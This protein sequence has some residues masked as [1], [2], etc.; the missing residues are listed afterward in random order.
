MYSNV[1]QARVSIRDTIWCVALTS[2]Y[3]GPLLKGWLWL[4]MAF[5]LE[6]LVTNLVIIKYYRT[7]L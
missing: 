1:S 6:N 2:L 7:L 4:G 5:L 3:S